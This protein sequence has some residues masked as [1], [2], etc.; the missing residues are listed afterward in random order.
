MAQWVRNLASIHEDE[1]T[2]A[3]L[4]HWLKGC[5]AVS[6]GVGSRHSLDL[7]LL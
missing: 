5:V 2:I 1:G 3:G 4:A 7:V 6:C